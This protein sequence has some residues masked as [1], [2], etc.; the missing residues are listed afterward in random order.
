MMRV[1][2]QPREQEQNALSH[3]FI[4][5]PFPPVASARGCLPP[6]PRSAALLLTLPSC[7]RHVD[8]DAGDL[9]LP[10]LTSEE[11]A[12]LVLVWCFLFFAAAANSEEVAILPAARERDSLVHRAASRIDPFP[13]PSSR[14]K[15][16]PFFP[17]RVRTPGSAGDPRRLSG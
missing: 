8:T 11:K 1:T 17:P 13:L 7:Y 4:S 14:S 9:Q 5:Q 2:V 16:T 6:A 10:P 15:P 12:S 3:L